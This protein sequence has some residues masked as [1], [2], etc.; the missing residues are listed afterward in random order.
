MNP[1]KSNSCERPSRNIL[2][3][4]PHDEAVELCRRKI[5]DLNEALADLFGDR[6][7]IKSRIPTA[8]RDLPIVELL[9]EN[10]EDLAKKIS[11]ELRRWQYRLDFLLV[12]DKSDEFD[13]DEIKEFPCGELLDNPVAS[14]GDRYYYMSPFREETKAS[15][16]WYKKTNSW[17]DFGSSEGGDVIALYM[18]LNNCSFIEACKVIHS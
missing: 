4:I 17:Y 3:Y 7:R 1:R 10:N 8:G 12:G 16:V 18:K 14:F 6:D 13:I 5:Y 9:L 11:Q 15:F 2:D